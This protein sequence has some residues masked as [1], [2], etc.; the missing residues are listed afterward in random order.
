MKQIRVLL[1]DEHT[2]VRSGIRALLEKVPEVEIV[3]EAGDG[4]EALHLIKLHQP[5]VA[6]IDF[7][8][9]KLSGLEVAARVGKDVPGVRVIIVSMYTSEGYV[10]QALRSR[11]V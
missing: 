4:R 5:D 7:T 6:L 3:G 1:A 11:A 9:P 8:L 10:R 2:L